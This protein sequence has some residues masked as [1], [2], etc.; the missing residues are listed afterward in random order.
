MTP[1]DPNPK[2]ARDTDRERRRKSGSRSRSATAVTGQ[3]VAPGSEEEA[4]GDENRR[5]E[6]P[7]VR[8]GEP[9]GSSPRRAAARKLPVAAGETRS[10]RGVS[11]DATQDDGVYA[12]RDERVLKAE[13]D[14]PKLH[15]V[16]AQAGLGSR[17]EM[18]ALIGDQ[19]VRVNGYLAHVG[20]RVQP[21]DEIRVDGRLIT[22]Q[23]EPARV[24]VL[25]YHKPVG[26][27]VTHSDPEQR[28]T[29]FARL[30][31]LRQGK[32]Q[33]VGRLDLNT[34]GLLLLTNSGDLANRLMHPRYGLEREY[35]VRVLGA[36]SLEEKQRLLG[37]VML[38]DGR[39]QFLKV[40]E[41]EAGEG[42]NRWYRVTI[43]EGRNRE[44]RRLFEALGHAVSRLIR[45]RYGPV[46]LPRGLRRGVW[47]E[48]AGA[49][50]EQVLGLRLEHGP[51]DGGRPRKTRAGGAPR[52]GALA[53][54]AEHGSRD[55]RDR[56]FGFRDGAER[57]GV[58]SRRK[59]EGSPGRRGRANAAGG[60]GRKVPPRA[61]Q[62]RAGKR[63][64]S[65]A[66]PRKS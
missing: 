17:L 13:P 18:E 45:V 16:L 5:P 40:I 63:M 57:P 64:Q 28:P 4:A 14:R 11:A 65:P 62:E 37:G 47:Q 6:R 51:R 36:L 49:E 55:R 9:G 30:P 23:S 7:R 38:A 26:E 29:V 34:E 59:S 41:E 8:S 19:R 20:Q 39:A 1:A 12:S 10:T 32:W 60:R 66:R 31:R 50:A 56:V 42:A 33:S 22:V 21:G 24:R 52:R 2:S 53:P 46:L 54:R 15:K 3:P 61:A 27:V 48:L 25:L 43:A 58:P 35:A 44:V